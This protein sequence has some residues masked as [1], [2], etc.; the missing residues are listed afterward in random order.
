MS[1]ITILLLI[2]SNNSLLADTQKEVRSCSDTDLSCSVRVEEGEIAAGEPLLAEVICENTSDDP[3]EFGSPFSYE[4]GGVVFEIMP[5]AGTEFNPVYTAHAGRVMSVRFSPIVLESHS[6]WAA[7]AILVVEEKLETQELKFV[8]DQVG[9]YQLRAKIHLKSGSCSTTPSKFDV[10][11]AS[12]RMNRHISNIKTEF[13]PDSLRGKT[14]E[15]ILYRALLGMDVMG[16]G[17]RDAH[18]LLQKELGDEEGYRILLL[19]DDLMFKLRAPKGEDRNLILS[20][21]SQLRQDKDAGTI[22]KNVA[23]E[24]YANQLAQLGRDTDAKAVLNTITHKTRLTR[25]TESILQDRSQSVDQ[26]TQPTHATP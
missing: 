26:A 15:K 12:E 24:V 9:E 17:R 3:I 16:S 1:L 19:M 7:R 20:R 13:K 11:T 21:I 18:Q 6:S 23:T 5:P 25:W 10:K 22:W 2:G 8:L 4:S 14:P